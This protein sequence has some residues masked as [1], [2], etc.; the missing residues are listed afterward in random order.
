MK[1]TQNNDR[2]VAMA[3]SGN[4]TAELL[5]QALPISQGKPTKLL[6]HVEAKPN[7]P[8]PSRQHSVPSRGTPALAETQWH[9]TQD[10]FR[11]PVVPGGD[12]GA[13]ML[14]VKGGTAKIHHPDGRALHA[15]LIPLLQGAQ[16]DPSPGSSSPCLT[17]LREPLEGSFGSP[18]ARPRTSS[19][20]Q[21]ATPGVTVA[22]S[23]LP[24]RSCTALKDCMEPTSP[25]AVSFLWQGQGH[26]EESQVEAVC[27]LFQV[28]GELVVRVHEEDVLWLEV[29]VG[30]FI[31]M[32]N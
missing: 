27:Y 9:L 2:A 11:G 21:P 14:V 23:A 8:Q 26:Q 15:P 4:S 10:D 32:Q 5:N 28:V 3:F 17:Q 20:H 18:T 13:V 6:N 31:V 1:Q 19:H 7:T 29:S 25:G 30:E 16:W 22:R 24:G 12:D